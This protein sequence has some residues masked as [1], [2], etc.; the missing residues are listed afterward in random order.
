[1]NQ[2]R[3]QLTLTPLAKKTFTPRRR[4]PKGGWSMA[5]RH[6]EPPGEVFPRSCSYYKLLMLRKRINKNEEK[7]MNK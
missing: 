1:M 2:L 7:K 6:A 5:N 3:Q 4:R